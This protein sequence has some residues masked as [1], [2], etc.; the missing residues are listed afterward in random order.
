[1]TVV[2][3]GLGIDVDSESSMVAFGLTRDLTAGETVTQAF[4]GSSIENWFVIDYG[5]GQ[6]KPSRSECRRIRKI[7][8]MMKRGNLRFKETKQKGGGIV[9][10]RD[11][12][13]A[14]KRAA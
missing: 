12:R 11:R 14:M 9:V 1:M 4:D 2:V 3:Q 10:T 8:D 7:I 5:C 6:R 13:P